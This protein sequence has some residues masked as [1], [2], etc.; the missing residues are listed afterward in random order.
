MVN[1]VRETST[2]TETKVPKYFG[3]RCG[4]QKSIMFV[5]KCLACDN[6][7]SFDTSQQNW[8]CKKCMEDP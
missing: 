2:Y 8:K 6:T 7:I 3:P 4:I 1:V 5:Y